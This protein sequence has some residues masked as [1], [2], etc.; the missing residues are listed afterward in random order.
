MN[1]PPALKADASRLIREAI[2]EIRGVRVEEVTGVHSAS[3][4]LDYAQVQVTL[5]GWSPSLHAF[6]YV[7]Q[8]E[9]DVPLGARDQCRQLLHEIRLEMGQ[10]ILRETEAKRH[11]IHQP[12]N[13]TPTAAPW[14]FDHIEVDQGTALLMRNREFGAKGTIT[15]I[16]EALHA[17]HDGDDNSGMLIGN[18]GTL[19]GARVA[20]EIAF[21]EEACWTDGELAVTQQLPDSIVHATVG[22]R[23]GDVAKLPDAIGGRIVTSV[24]QGPDGATFRTDPDLVRIGDLED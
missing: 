18:D 3:S 20:I 8:G 7:W 19:H 14:A 4:L 9:V 2:E 5:V 21:G 1:L 11:G 12:I 17:N 22:R 6:R 10:Q 13:I 23:L 24:E 16:L 15:A